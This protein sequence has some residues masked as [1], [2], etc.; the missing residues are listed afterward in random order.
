MHQVADHLR[1]RATSLA[2]DPAADLFARSAFNRYY[3]AAYLLVRATLFELEGHRATNHASLPQ[4]LNGDFRRTVLRRVERA[5]RSNWLSA[6]RHGQLR[7]KTLDAVTNL[8]QMLI[9][10]YS[11]RIVAD[12]EIEIKAAF[13]NTSITLHGCKDSEAAHWHRKAGMYCKA[14]REVWNDTERLQ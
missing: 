10:A 13:S 9:D 8:S 4:H 5:F 14:L 12:Y 2:D 3:Y 11:V 6:Q 1:N 7:H